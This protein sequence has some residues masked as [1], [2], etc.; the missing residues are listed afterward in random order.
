[1]TAA[2]AA[3]QTA[4]LGGNVRI[5]VADIA[6]GVVIC[7]KKGFALLG[8]VTLCAAVFAFINPEARGVMT[9]AATD[10]SSQLLGMPKTVVV[11]R[12]EAPDMDAIEAATRDA[13]NRER[14]LASK[15][16]N[17][18]REQKA[19]AQFLASKYKLAPEAIGQVVA[20]AFRTGQQV[21]VDPLL[22][23]AVMSIESSMNPFA[24]S[25][26]GAR[27]LMQVMP[28]VHA[29]KLAGFGGAGAAFHPLVNIRVGAQILR[30]LIERNGSVEAGLHAYLGAQ[31][32][33]DDNGYG[34]R[35]MS[36]RARIEAAMR[37]TRA[38]Q[39]AANTV[40]KPATDRASEAP[41]S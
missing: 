12:T 32:G 11:V 38:V 41:G 27:G 24:Q 9:Q 14:E 33:V 31:P 28:V 23:L 13:L 17:L 29:D 8:I 16:V 37:G 26:M 40:A 25:P 5:V 30:E 34:D 19:A 20:E 22:L 18:T 1:M 15:P 4:R 39:T 10:L 21:K 2:N 36:E 35:V 6:S 3:N 7:A